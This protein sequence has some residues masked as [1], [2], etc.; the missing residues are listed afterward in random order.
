MAKDNLKDMKGGK[1]K[2]GKKAMRGM[3]KKSGRY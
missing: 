1:E 3:G 2:D